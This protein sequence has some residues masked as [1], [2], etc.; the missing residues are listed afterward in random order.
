[1]DL[2][3]A[4]YSDTI[5]N[6]INSL[7]SNLFSSVDRTLY[8]LLDELVFIDST[9]INDSFFDKAFGN[10]YSIG[11]ISLANSLLI[12]FVIYYCIRLFLSNYTATAVESP[13]Q[14]LFKS[15]I[16]LICITSS[17]FL[18]QQI[19]DINSLISDG[20]CEISQNIFNTDI[21]FS[22]LINQLNSYIYTDSSSFNLFSFDGIIK[23]FVSIGLLNLLFS[24][25]LR[26]IMI[27]VFI[28]LSP[29]A[30]L[31][32]ITRSTSWFFKTWIRN[33]IS[34]LLLQSFISLIFLIIFS[35]DGTFSSTFSQLMYIGAIYALTRSNHFMRELFGGISID[36]SSNLSGFKF[37]PK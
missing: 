4:N 8:S 7:F 36:I 5:M 3:Q 22:S 16:F 17:N 29:F 9:I 32:L 18:C 31:S 37:L 24:Y 15:V 30:F 34:L 23:S 26:Y 27:K 12:G 11:L 35:F 20:I 2:S 21:S 33:F 14:F 1:M 28:L 19:I 13:F 10:T 6:T 25:S